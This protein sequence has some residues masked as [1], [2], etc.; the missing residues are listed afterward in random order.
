[1]GVSTGIP[2]VDRMLGTKVAQTSHQSSPTDNYDYPFD[3]SKPPQVDPNVDAARV[4]TFYTVNSMH[5]LT[6]RTAL[7]SVRVD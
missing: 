7:A 5:D 6:V 1:M 2:I 3:P 4:N